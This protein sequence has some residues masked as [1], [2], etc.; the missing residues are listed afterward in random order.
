MRSGGGPAR[1]MMRRAAGGWSRS[2]ARVAM[3]SIRGSGV[4]VYSPIRV[5][6]SIIPG[7]KGGASTSRATGRSL[8]MSKSPM[9][10]PQTA[11]IT[12]RGP[13]GTTTSCPSRTPPSG[14]R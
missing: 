12:R 10:G 13:K 1:W 7:V 2:G 4:R 5:R 11:P 6:N 3:R 9:P 8:A 14:A